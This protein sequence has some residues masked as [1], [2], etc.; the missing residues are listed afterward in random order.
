MHLYERNH[1]LERTDESTQESTLVLQLSSR[2]GRH[3]VTTT[4]TLPTSTRRHAELRRG[5]GHRLPRI[6]PQK[7]K[8]GKTNKQKKVTTHNIKH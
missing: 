5:S 8:K 7:K 2:R 6:L 1:E 4:P 3:G